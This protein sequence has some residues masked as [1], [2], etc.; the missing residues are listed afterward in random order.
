MVMDGSMTRDQIMSSLTLSDPKH[1]REN[2]LQVAVKQQLISMTIP[3][4]PQSKNQKFFLTALG[5]TIKSK[6]K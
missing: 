1:F 4:K 3:D 2:Y 5:V 6:N